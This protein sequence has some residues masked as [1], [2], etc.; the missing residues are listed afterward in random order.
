VTGSDESGRDNVSSK[1]AS[2]LMLL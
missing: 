2:P 1:S